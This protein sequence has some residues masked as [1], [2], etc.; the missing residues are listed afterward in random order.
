MWHQEKQLELK[1]HSY[2]KSNGTPDPRCDCIEDENPIIKV[3]SWHYKRYETIA[4]H[5]GMDYPKSFRI[6]VRFITTSG[7]LDAVDEVI[8]ILMIL[9]QYKMD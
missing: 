6:E 4:H 7:Q 9:Y 3:S 2:Q 8:K 5:N 1:W